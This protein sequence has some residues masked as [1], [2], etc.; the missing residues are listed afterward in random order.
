MKITEQAQLE[1][2]KVLDGYDKPGA[3]IRIF[4]SKGC[5]GPSIQMDIAMNVSTNETTISLQEIDFFVANDLLNT[6]ENVTIDYGTNGFRLEGIK[7][8]GGCCS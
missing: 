7:K 8:E 6:V 3:G 2:K 1:L 5:C 4:S